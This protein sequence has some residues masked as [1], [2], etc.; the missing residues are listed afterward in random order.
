MSLTRIAPREADSE[1]A[2]SSSNAPTI[3]A[4]PKTFANA[5]IIRTPLFLL[6]RAFFGWLAA[7]DAY[8][9]LDLLTAG[10]TWSTS[11]GLAHRN[12]LTSR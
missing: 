9:V 8:P 5:V 4:H 1:D 3:D 12:L 7:A 10:L 11:T 2:G 6:A